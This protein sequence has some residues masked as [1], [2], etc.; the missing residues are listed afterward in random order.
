MLQVIPPRPGHPELV[1]MASGRTSLGDL[2]HVGIVDLYKRHGAILFRGFG[3]DL[4]AFGRFA[5]SFCRSAVVNESPNR[6]PLD[7]ANHVYAV[8]GG[9]GAFPLHPELSREPWKPDVAFFACLGAP[10]EG[11]TT[12]ICD[13]VDLVRRLP[14]AAREGLVARRLVYG[15]GTW[16]ALLAFWLG[17]VTPSEALLGAPPPG[18]PYRFERLPDGRIARHFSRP[19]LHRPMFCDAP[20]FGNF[21]LFARYNNGRSDFPLLDDL[22]PVPEVWVEAAKS[23]GDL[24]TREIAWETGDVLMLD[25]T[26]FMHGRTAIVDTAERRIATYFGYLDFAIPDPEEPVDPIWRRENFVPPQPPGFS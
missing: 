25:N 20:A 3:T 26:R 19:A 5:R 16:P 17:T 6:E 10:G 18:C 13:G 14:A 1:V 9:T 8:D 21:L 23:A 15:M 11:G 24:L 7:P 12:T 22:R 4:A 2:D